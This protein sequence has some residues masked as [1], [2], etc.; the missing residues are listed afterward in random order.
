VLI[1]SENGI[2]YNLILLINVEISLTIRLESA[3][4]YLRE[5]LSKRSKGK[6]SRKKYFLS[7]YPL[8]LNQTVFISFRKF[9]KQIPES[10]KAESI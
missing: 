10:S 5:L 7:P 4:S 3:D 9:T 8:C 1:S 2:Y 6:V